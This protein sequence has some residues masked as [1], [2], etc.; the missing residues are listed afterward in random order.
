MRSETTTRCFSGATG[1]VFDEEGDTVIRLA[2]EREL[3]AAF[4]LGGIGNRDYS[5]VAAPP[6]DGAGR[7]PNA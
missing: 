1:G 2:V 3:D 6:D 4:A 5:Y 7:P